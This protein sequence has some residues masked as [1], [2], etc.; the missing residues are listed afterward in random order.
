MSE[1]NELAAMFPHID[2]PV[3]TQ[4]LILHQNDVEE[5]IEYLLNHPSNMV[6]AV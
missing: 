6:R 5:S 2:R 1:V 3:L 4:V